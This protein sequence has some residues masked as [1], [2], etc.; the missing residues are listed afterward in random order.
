[1]GEEKVEEIEKETSLEEGV[2]LDESVEVL[3]VGVVEL[4]SVKMS[5]LKAVAIGVET[6]L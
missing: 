6:K 2:E 3:E 5:V 4:I 1:M